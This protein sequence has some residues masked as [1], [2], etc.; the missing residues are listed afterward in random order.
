[1]SIKIVNFLSY[2]KLPEGNAMVMQQ[3]PIDWRYLLYK[4]YVLGLCFRKYLSKIW[5]YM[6]QYLHFRILK[7]PLIVDRSVWADF[8][9]TSRGDRNP[10]D[11]GECKG[12]YPLLWPNYSGEW[13]I[14]IYPDMLQFKAMKLYENMRIRVNVTDVGWWLFVI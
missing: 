6:V 3:E 9:T 10:I 4:A 2:V 12:K 1:M 8:I 13:N 7:S 14:V 5:P 11:D